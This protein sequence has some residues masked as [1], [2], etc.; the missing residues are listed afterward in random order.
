MSTEKHN[1]NKAIK[2]SL[3]IIVILF[4]IIAS[5]S[6]LRPKDNETISIGPSEVV[7]DNYCEKY[8][9]SDD[10]DRLNEKYLKLMKDYSNLKG[11]NNFEYDI[12]PF[13]S[14]YADSI[15]GFIFLNGRNISNDKLKEEISY[16][17]SENVSEIY[18]DGIHT[19]NIYDGCYILNVLST[20]DELNDIV[21]YIK[22]YNVSVFINNYATYANYMYSFYCTFVI[23]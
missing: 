15:I 9:E 5:F 8:N 16:L 20:D 7:N 19:T 23:N 12:E 11:W 4:F 18:V 2:I 21:D 14:N 22:P 6:Y 1:E 3:I 10:Y 13:T 17:I